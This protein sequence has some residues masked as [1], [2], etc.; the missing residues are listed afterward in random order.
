MRLISFTH[1]HCLKSKEGYGHQYAIVF[2]AVAYA[3]RH[4]RLLNV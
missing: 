1:T 2:D 4:R 3:Y